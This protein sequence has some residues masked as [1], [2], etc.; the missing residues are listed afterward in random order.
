MSDGKS[1][2]SN[3]FISTLRSVML[4]SAAFRSSRI[5]FLPASV[6]HNEA[7][8][9]GARPPVPIVRSFS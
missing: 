1:D 8:Y 7:E 4:E 6:L 5:L 2:N 3:F 9:V